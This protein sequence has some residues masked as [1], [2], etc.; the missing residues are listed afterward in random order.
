MD[1]QLTFKSEKEVGTTIS[2][3]IVVA[4]EENDN[5]LSHSEEQAHQYNISHFNHIG[6]ASSWPTEMDPSLNSSQSVRV[7]SYH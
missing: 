3:T 2:F 6:A 7:S 5:G 4:H 1:G